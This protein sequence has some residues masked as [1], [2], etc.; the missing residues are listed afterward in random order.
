MMEPKQT[1][2]AVAVANKSFQMKFTLAELAEEDAKLRQPLMEAATVAARLALDP[3]DRALR[4]SAAKAWERVDSMMVE[5]L[6]KEDRSV[7]PWAESRT[8]F[9]HYLVE[10]AKRK[11]EQLMALRDMILTSSFERDSDHEVAAAARNLCVFATTL[12]DLIA[13]EQRELFPLMR[14]LLFPHRERSA[15]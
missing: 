7:L 15:P 10:R 1:E 6:R 12:D 11:H 9:P 4:R 8:D 2:K 5:H 3:A 13:G 14:R